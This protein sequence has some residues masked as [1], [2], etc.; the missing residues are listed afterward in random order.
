MRTVAPDAPVEASDERPSFSSRVL[1]AVAGP[2]LIVAC[3]L[4]A[5]RG[6]VFRGFLSDQHPDILAFWLPRWCFLG[7]SLR[8][9]HVPLWNPLQFAGVPFVA[10]PQSGWL[11]APVMALFSLFGSSSAG[12]GTALRGFIVL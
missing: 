12:C 5:L 7:Q 3:V 9:G 10:D 2:A 4:F 6:I 1:P 11:Y 8:A